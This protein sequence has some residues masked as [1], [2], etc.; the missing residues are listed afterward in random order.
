M[1]TMSHHEHYY[2]LGYNQNLLGAAY[3]ASALIHLIRGGADAELRWTATAHS[4]AYGLLSL[5]GKPS[6]AAL[7]KQLFAQH[8]RY[9]DEISFP[10]NRTASPHLD[11]IVS[12][13]A[14]RRV[15]AVF[16]NSSR[17]AITIA[18]RDIDIALEQCDSVFRLDRTTGER[19]AAEKLGSE[20][21]LNGYGIGVITNTAAATVFD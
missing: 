21:T 12:H 11:S 20:F 6:P 9:G 14:G 2:T 3:Y 4:D 18:P 19:V 17:T 5:E 10:A 13:G 15:S 7:A 8:V 16:V 1:N